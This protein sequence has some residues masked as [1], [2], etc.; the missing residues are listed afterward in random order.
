MDCFYAAV[1]MRDDPRLRD[2]PIAIG[3]PPNT[4]SVLC[5]SNYI[6]RK[7]G[8]RSAMPSSVAVRK[9]PQLTIIPPNFKKYKEAS[10]M[11]Y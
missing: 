4:R 11:A 3:G 10:T 7:Y 1:E 5:T 9:C 2:I 8:V 6:A